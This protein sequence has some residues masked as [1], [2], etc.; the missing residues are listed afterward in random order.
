[1]TATPPNEPPPW[2][3]AAPQAPQAPDDLSR[4][5][6]FVVGL[7]SDLPPQLRPRKVEAAECDME[8]DVYAT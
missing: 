5:G 4:Y 3:R 1:M 8:Y 2:K 7:A 6:G